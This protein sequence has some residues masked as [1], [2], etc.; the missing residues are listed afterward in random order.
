MFLRKLMFIGLLCF[1]LASC[2]TPSQRRYQ[3]KPYTEYEVQVCLPDAGSI[4][5]DQTGR[6]S[7][8]SLFVLPFGKTVDEYRIYQANLPEIDPTRVMV[9]AVSAG[10]KRQ[11]F[12]FFW[13]KRPDPK[14]VGWSPWVS[15]DLVSNTNPSMDVVHGGYV[16]GSPPTEPFPLMRYR[17]SPKEE[18]NWIVER[19]LHGEK[20]DLPSCVQEAHLTTHSSG[21]SSA[22]RTRA[23]KFRR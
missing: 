14:Q 3:P 1:C 7:I 5:G 10:G 12:S 21:R 9:I 22:T 8:A 16:D 19:R 6:F 17:L 18:P 15:A 13:K 11:Y 20:V 4:S 2:S 23:A